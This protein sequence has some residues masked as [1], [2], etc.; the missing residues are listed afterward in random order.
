MDD[1]KSKLEE[2]RARQAQLDEELLGV[3]ERRA[4]LSREVRDLVGDGT[5]SA[6][7][8]D[9]AALR[10]L[11]QK[12]SGVVPAASVRAVFRSVF[13]A[14]RALEVPASVAYQGP[15]GG[16][17][18]HV[19]RE[20]FGH[21]AE[22]IDC[23]SP[24]AALDEVV[25]KR[26]SYAVFPFESSTDGVLQTAVS[27][28]AQTDLYI[29]AERPVQLHIDLLNRT[30]NLADVDKVYATGAALAACELFLE[31]TMPSATVLDVKSPSMAIQLA[32]EDHGSAAL[33]P[34]GTA[35][36]T[37]LRVVRSNV[38]DE[39]DL[40]YRYGFVSSRP[41]SRSGR[42]S[43]ALLFSVDD[44]PGALFEALKHFAERGVNLEKLQSRPVR[45]EN[46]DYV[47]YVEVGG[48]VT[49]RPVV[50]AL[51]AIKRSTKYLKVLGSFASET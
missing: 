46:W 12:A 51:E 50:T 36:D 19:A 22:L 32:V 40:M 11:E 31:K 6:E 34:H 29:V 42:D 27:A 14:A 7:H 30:G 9:D 33:V 21:G 43:T 39:P 17:G 24:A 45:G 41:A 2:L 1:K 25:R 20:Y 4:K 26:A 15:E 28:L 13:A 44:A 48:H 37:E 10:K 47:F 38:G 3:I 18:Q 35:S 23:P 5:V 8:P 16:L 49:D